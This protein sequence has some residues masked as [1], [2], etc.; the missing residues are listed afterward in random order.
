MGRWLGGIGGQDRWE[1]VGCGWGGWVRNPGMPMQD[2]SV[3]CL[4]RKI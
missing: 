2:R 4:D 1:G 3:G